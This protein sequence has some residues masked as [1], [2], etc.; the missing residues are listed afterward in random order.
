MFKI[1]L[2]HTENDP[3]EEASMRM[4]HQ[5]I[6]EALSSLDEEF[7]AVIVLRDVENCDYEQ[8][9][10]IVQVPK[11]DLVTDMEFKELVLMPKTPLSTPLPAPVSVKAGR[12]AT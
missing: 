4:D 2:F 6:V 3:A 1:A 9:A 10:E 7:R 12:F 11:P 5:R 8:I